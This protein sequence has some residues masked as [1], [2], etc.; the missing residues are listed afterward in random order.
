MDSHQ[1]PIAPPP[2]VETYESLAT[3]VEHVMLRPDMSTDDIAE[4]CRTAVS[5]GVGAVLVRPCDVEVA[6]RWLAGTGV[7][8]AATV[9]HPYGTSTTATKLYEGR[10]LL[11]LGAKELDFVINSASLRSR[12]FQHVETELMQI[13]RSCHED[14]A[15]LKVVLNNRFLATD[16]KI[17]ATKISKRVEAD[18]LSLD[19]IE[20]D[21]ALIQPILKSAAELKCSG[22]VDHLDQILSVRAAGFS[23]IGVTSTHALLSE[24]K[25]RLEAL[26]AA[27]ENSSS[28]S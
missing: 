14:G 7:I 8:V 24:W 25:A 27:R 13:V 4:G 21:V 16:L 28:P 15:K 6:V 2:P 18:F 3:L 20:Q 5:F 9:N 19:Y 22:P 23:R 10:E 17:I 12:Q 26:K 11:R 1:T